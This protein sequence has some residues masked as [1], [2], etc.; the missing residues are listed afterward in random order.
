MSPSSGSDLAHFYHVACGNRRTTTVWRPAAEDHFRLLAAA[1]FTGE[2]RVGLVGS[3]N[4][5]MV[6]RQWLAD[7]WPSAE[8]CATQEYGNEQVTLERLRQYACAHPESLISYAHPKG[9]YHATERQD[10]W[11]KAM[12]AACTT[13]WRQRV[14]DLRDHDAV[15][16]HWL[17]ERRF[18]GGNFWWATARYLS[19]LPSPRGDRH[20]AEAWIGLGNPHVLALSTDL[21][22]YPGDDPRPDPANIPFTPQQMPKGTPGVTQKLLLTL[23][24][25]WPPSG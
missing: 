16:L 9:S 11:R 5:A 1:G 21:P 10:N 3:W 15:G 7:A 23:S 18:F 4:Y 22:Q 20:D 2:V 25:P 6:F 17:A 24:P 12:E 8:I 13:E 14:E 19:T